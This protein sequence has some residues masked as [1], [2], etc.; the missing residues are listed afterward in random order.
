MDI[1]N[2]PIW[3]FILVGFVA[4]MI[5]GALGMAYGVSSTTVLVSLGV[6]QKF[7]SAD[8]HATEVVIT[9]ITGLSQRKSS[10]ALTR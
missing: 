4:Q 3:A 2:I 5:D 7:A 8:V 10:A 9:G 6:P 1:Q